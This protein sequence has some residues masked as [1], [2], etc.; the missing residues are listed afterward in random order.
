LVEARLVR[1]RLARRIA[2]KT[3]KPLA[4]VLPKIEPFIDDDYDSLDLVEAIMA[5]E[6]EFEVELPDDDDPAG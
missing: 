3:G 4:E 6:E 5:L 1:E 2:D